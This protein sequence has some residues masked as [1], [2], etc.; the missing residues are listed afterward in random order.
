MFRAQFAAPLIV[1]FSL[2][3]PALASAEPVSQLDDGQ[4]KSNYSTPSGIRYGWFWDANVWVDIAVQNLAYDKRV[5][6]VWTTDGW[7]TTE[8]SLAEYEGGYGE[9]WERWGVDIMPAAEMRSCFWCQPEPV[10]F[11]YAIFYEVR[12]TTYWDSNGFANYVIDLETTY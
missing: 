7:Q 5:G 8:V 3:T 12:G 9:G 11:E 1:L 6:I 4:W 2:V 10:S